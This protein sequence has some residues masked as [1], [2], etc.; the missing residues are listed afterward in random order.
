MAYSPLLNALETRA[1][2]FSNA[3]AGESAPPQH[4]MRSFFPPTSGLPGVLQAL[5]GL[6][7]GVRQKS[8]RGID[9]IYVD[10]GDIATIAGASTTHQTSGI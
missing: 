9:E 8:D 6:C 5:Q 2:R 4:L 3:G 1:Q 7:G 10:L